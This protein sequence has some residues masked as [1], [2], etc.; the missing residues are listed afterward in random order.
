[1][2]ERQYRICNQPADVGLYCQR[3]ADEIIAKALSPQFGGRGERA[4]RPLPA[5]PSVQPGVIE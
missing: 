4:H 1:M 5:T 3:C 2:G